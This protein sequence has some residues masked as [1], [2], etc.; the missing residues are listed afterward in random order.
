MTTGQKEL[1]RGGS[2]RKATVRFYG[3]VKS[4]LSVYGTLLTVAQLLPALFGFAL[5]ALTPQA[6]LSETLRRWAYGGILAGS[7]AGIVV[8]LL[9]S[10]RQPG[11]LLGAVLA[12]FVA[13]GALLRFHLSLS[14][15][16]FTERWRGFQLLYDFYLGTGDWQQRLYNALA[17]L[18]FAGTLFAATL[19]VPLFVAYR[20]AQRRTAMVA[21]ATPDFAAL[22]AALKSL[23]AGVAEAKA[24]NARLLQ[25]NARLRRLEVQ[26]KTLEKDM[27]EGKVPARKTSARN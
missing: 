27:P 24:V 12:L 2:L 26:H 6:W 17:G 25:E 5:V 11:W 18:G 16:M 23:T 7:L 14:N 4:A 19:L 10:R 15:V 1:G 3:L 21:G 22:E 8:L 9:L 20:S 13:S